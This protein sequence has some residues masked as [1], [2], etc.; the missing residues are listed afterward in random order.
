MEVESNMKD[1]WKKNGSAWGSN[2][3]W[4]ATRPNAGVE[5]RRAHRDPTTPACKDT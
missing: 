2:P 3:P 1:E 5:D 4:N